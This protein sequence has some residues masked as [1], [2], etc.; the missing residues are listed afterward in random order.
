[1]ID[2]KSKNKIIEVYKNLVN[3]NLGIKEIANLVGLKDSPEVLIEILLESG[4]DVDDKDIKI[5]DKRKAEKKQKRTDLKE[6]IK[7]KKIKKKEINKVREI[8]SNIYNPYIHNKPTITFSNDGTGFGKSYGVFKEFIKNSDDSASKRMFFITP[9]K[10]QIKIDKNLIKEANKKNIEFLSFLSLKDL[11]N[12]SFKDWITEE[13]NRE[14]YTRWISLIKHKNTIITNE[15]KKLES[16]INS[17]EYLEDRLNSKYLEMEYKI[18]LEEDLV[19]KSRDLN[20]CLISLALNILN[21]NRLDNVRLSANE[22]FKLAE[23]KPKDSVYKIYSEILKTIFPFEYAKYKVCI[24]LS[25]TKKFDTSVQMITEKRNGNIQNESCS[26]YSVVGGK[27]D[28]YNENIGSLIG[29]EDREQIEFLKN[30]YFVTDE[31]NYFRRNNISFEIVVDE[32][33][34]S[35]ETFLDSGR[36][37]LLDKKCKMEDVLAGT[38]RIYAS[39]KDRN[40]DDMTNSFSPSAIEGIAFSNNLENLYKNN[41]DASEHISIFDFLKMFSGNVDGIAINAN[42][43]EQIS[44]ITKNVFNYNKKNYFNENA[45]KNIKLRSHHN[46]SV[47]EAYTEDQYEQEEDESE[48]N[49]SMYDLYQLIMVVLAACSNVNTQGKLYKSLGMR[50]ERNQNN[51]LNI[52][53]SKANSVK[54]YIEYIF[55]RSD[56]EDMIIDHFF[57]YFLPK[58]I[59]S[60]EKRSD[61]LFK[62]DLPGIIYADFELEL[63]TELPEVNI[64]KILYQTNNTVISLS[65]TSG[66]ANS[67]SENYNRGVLYKY[68]DEHAFNYRIVK[69]TYEDSKKME[70]L[71]NLREVHRDIDFIELSEMSTVIKNE[72]KE[73]DVVREVN[74]LKNKIQA[75]IFN[76]HHMD[77]FE[78]QINSLVLAAKDEKHTLI[79]SNTNN[80]IRFMKKYI[81]SEK[82]K[83][84][85]KI[86]VLENTNDSIFEYTPFGEEQKVRVVL[87]NA[88]TDREVIVRDYT[89]INDTNTKLVF[90]SSYNSAGTGL[91]YFINYK[92][93]ISDEELEEDFERLVLASSPFYSNVKTKEGF[94]TIDNYLILLKHYSEYTNTN[95]RL[96]DFETNIINNE[97]FEILIN[98]HN[99]SIFKKILQA[100]GRIERK[101]SVL[102][103]EI[104]LPES[105]VSLCTMQFILLNNNVQNE[106]MI[107]SMS[108]L[109][110]RFMSYCLNKADKNSFKN[111]CDRKEFENKIQDDGEQ[112]KYLIQKIIVE[113]E[114]DAFRKGI[115]DDISINELLR[116]E[117][118]IL[119]PKK[120]IKELKSHPFIIENEY[121]DII[122]LFYIDTESEDYKDIKICKMI[123]D[124]RKLTDI[125]NGYEVYNPFNYILPSY[126]KSIYEDRNSLAFKVFAK[127]I[128]INKFN[129][130]Y[131]PNPYLI[132]LLLGNIGECIFK[133]VLNEKGIDYLSTKEIKDELYPVLYELFD[134]YII[135]DDKLVCIDVKNW[136]MIND[137]EERSLKTI[138]SAENKI[139]TVKKIVGDKFKEIHFAYVNTKIEE[140]SINVRSEKTK[141]NIYFLNL[142][143][144]IDEYKHKD[145][146][147]VKIYTKLEL[148]NILDKL[149]TTGENK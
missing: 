82:G 80:F 70:E 108:L 25:T 29:Q 56:D 148:N 19:K 72:D 81:T 30:E 100:I 138:S 145:T 112:I 147:K 63:R 53:I 109:N 65:A 98:E 17:I 116:S 99:L 135:V 39:C 27:I 110:T 58:T 24:L 20:N 119:N 10:A 120:I 15:I 22:I 131:L 133:D 21:D 40:K 136:S 6:S 84:D 12:L 11:H 35:Y 76:K 62:P 87:F 18:E 45:L 28:E 85:A 137:T 102:K 75:E 16:L 13:S 113:K 7:A 127:Y 59:F 107:N 95:K 51:P 93:N 141:D 94:N 38:F 32:E 139:N 36:V 42:K 31:N 86:K 50:K 132:P 66:I 74:S 89:E 54:K 134:F 77:E 67:F 111:E 47:C 1:M 122:D 4:I 61:F 125:K 117:D 46:N 118:L 149:I 23:K 101:D 57:T 52:F 104:Y 64:M 142:F 8:I 3:S 126:D 41:C 91:N 123:S 144:R 69:R 34:D 2:K 55:N 115:N 71:R 48:Y 146:N 14:K 114:V 130:R 73:N 105:L 43:I 60:I 106:I 90:I 143:K 5:K 33:H 88:E 37:Q 140:N 103:S 124:S 92:C 121:D 83:M 26:F 79:L 68:S 44:N 9:Q 128:S 78:R 129:N 49:P 96:K 97:N